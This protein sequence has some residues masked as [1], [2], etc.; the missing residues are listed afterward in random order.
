MRIATTETVSR[1]SFRTKVAHLQCRHSATAKR[2][3]THHLRCRLIPSGEPHFLNNVFC[4]ANRKR[5]AHLHYEI[6]LSACTA[7]LC[8]NNNRLTAVH[9]VAYTH[10]HTHSTESMRRH[11]ATAP[12]TPTEPTP[13]AKQFR[14]LLRIR[15]NNAPDEIQPESN[16]QANRNAV[17][18][19]QPV[20]GVELRKGMDGRRSRNNF[21]I[22]ATRTDCLWHLESIKFGRECD[23]RI[24][25]PPP[26]YGLCNKYV[27]A[28]TEIIAHGSVY[29]ARCAALVWGRPHSINLRHVPEATRSQFSFL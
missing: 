11:D 16:L 15:L 12:T 22:N 9:S 8:C 13:N 6:V 26:C 17:L 3:C 5:A 4:V 24:C 25:M 20:G 29:S 7:H 10:T 19:A 14:I 28:E 21:V 1:M 2:T 27:Y 18:E 23:V